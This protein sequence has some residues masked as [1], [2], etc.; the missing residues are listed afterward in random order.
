MNTLG[1]VPS[2][3]QKVYFGRSH[4]EQTLGEVVKVNRARAKVKQLESRGT[5]KSHPVGT[6]WTV[7]FSLLTPA[8][9]SAVPVVTASAPAPAPL[10]VFPATRRA[11]RA[12]LSDIANVYGQLSPENLTCDGELPASAVRRR[13]SALRSKLR[14]LFQEIGRTVSETEAYDAVR[15]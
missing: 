12:I 5:L 3:G 1:F 2:K 10:P 9:D 15:G 6:V 7:P 8:P 14:T 13:A 11:D 4:G